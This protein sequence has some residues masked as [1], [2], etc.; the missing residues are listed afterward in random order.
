MLQYHTPDNKAKMESGVALT[1]EDRWDWLTRLRQEAISKIDAGA[2]G[3]ALACSALKKIY[4]DELRVAGQSRSDIDV[5][6]VYLHANEDLLIERVKQ[7][8][9]HYMKEGM[10]HGQLKTLEKPD[11]D[12]ERDCLLVD[13][14]APSE[15]AQA[16]ALQAV[17]GAI[18]REAAITHAETSS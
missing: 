8:Q 17:K 1:D 6:F 14:S 2:S 5:H 13:V 11:G 15:E 10:V 7:R 9:G 4:R 12:E 18:A 3:V 16:N